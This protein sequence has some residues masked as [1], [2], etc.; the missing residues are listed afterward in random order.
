[1]ALSRNEELL[2]KLLNGETSDITP[3]SRMEAYLKALCEKGLGSGSGGGSSTGG[4]SSWNDLT[5]KP[6]GEAEAEIFSVENASFADL[7]LGIPM[8]IMESTE[9]FPLGLINGNTYTVIW[10][11]VEYECIAVVADGMEM[12]G[13]MAIMT[14]EDTGEPFV[15]ATDDGG[16]WVDMVGSSDTHTISVSGLTVFPI[17]EKYLPNNGE[18]D[19]TKTERGAGYI[20]NKPF[21]ISATYTYEWDGDTTDKEV[22][23][24]NT[25]SD[26][27]KI[28][29]C[30]ISDE[31]INFP[32]VSA[33]RMFNKHEDNDYFVTESEY[34]V[35]R[36]HEGTY[37]GGKLLASEL[38]S[39]FDFF[40]TKSSGTTPWGF[41]VTAGVYFVFFEDTEG[42]KYNYSEKIEF[43]EVERLN[44]IFLSN[45][46]YDPEMA[47]TFLFLKSCTG[48]SVKTFRIKVDDTGTLTAEEFSY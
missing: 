37:Y 42:N 48:G 30:K 24:V 23:E 4:V 1:M 2:E 38:I 20:R 43:Y 35:A 6:F 17:D 39:D 46:I 18:V 33:Y 3:Q 27:A 14:G 15:Y 8:Y 44:K 16:F 25:R 9:E 28:Y 31:T 10:D 26:G 47:P 45:E 13:N 12:L 11:G 36:T 7:G 32:W 5:D 29:L 41:D 19:F 34:R 22:I 40:A 21:Y